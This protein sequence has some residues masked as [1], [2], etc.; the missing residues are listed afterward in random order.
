M[1]AGAVDVGTRATRRLR[2]ALGA[3]TLAL[4]GL[5]AVYAGLAAATWGTWGDLDS[6]T[7]YDVV[8]GSL[9]AQ[10]QLPYADFVY[11][12]GPLA[13]L[14]AG[15]VTWLGGAG[16]TAVVALG[17]LVTAGIVAATYALARTFVGPLGGFLAAALTTAVAFIPN[18]YSYVLP[19][20]MAATL[21]TLL[22]L[23]LLLALARLARRD[24][25][26]WTVAAGLL[27]GLLTLTKP[28]PTLAGVA[29]VAAWL[30]ARRWAGRSVGRTT[31][32]LAGAALAVPVLVYGAFLL[33]VSPHTLFLENLFPADTI[34]GGG[35]VLLRARMP[36]TLESFVELG[37]RA[38][39]YAAGLGLIL[40][41]AKLAERPGLGRGVAAGLV[42][43][44]GLAACAAA[45]V[46]PEALRHGLQFVYG[47]VPF[48]AAAGAVWLLVR[49]R[50]R[51]LGER[52]DLRLAAAVALAAVAATAYNGFYLHAHFPQMAVY[53]APLVAVFLA[54]LHLRTLGRSRPAALLGIAWLAFL[55]AAG[56]GLTLKDARAESVTVHGPEGSL[57]ETPAEAHMYATALAAIERETAP[58]DRI[59]VLPLLTGLEALSGREPGLPEISVLPGVLERENGERDA[60]AYLQAHPVDLVVTDDRAWPAYGRGAFGESF[61]LALATWIEETYERVATVSAGTAE[62]RTL[63]IW[64]RT[65]E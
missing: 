17:L 4:V 1:T 36:L 9:V 25:T 49:A 22:L 57:A 24:T 30:L 39:V 56:T 3:D 21:G 50:R 18:N 44:G 58:G 51:S 10:G 53:Y 46:N 62:P 15:L 28:E 14:L 32:T 7:G 6:D 63:T 40:A 11:Y 2:L 20:T 26:G 37:G 45:L 47:W 61:G 52:D 42:L 12:Y 27:L 64:R 19:H 43:T 60:L 31:A 65:T 33:S 48:G 59:L 35:D 8:A 23:C 54:E 29:A 5:A 55:V 16:V 13:P 41:L 34:S 38:V